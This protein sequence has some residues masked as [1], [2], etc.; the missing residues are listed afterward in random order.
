MRISVALSN[1]GGLSNTSKMPCKSYGLPAQACK[2]GAKLVKIKGSTCEGC[3]ALKGAYAWPTV[4][5]AYNR[6]IK[7]LYS[8]EWV[9]SMAVLI[10]REKN[11]VFRWHDSGDLQSLQHLQ[12]I[13]EV[14]KLTPTIRHW[15]P[16]REKAIINSHQSVY[17]DNL[18][19]RLSAAMVDGKPPTGQWLTS[20][21]HSKGADHIGYE[22]KAYE[23]DGKCNDC[24]KCW[25]N[26]VV[27][28]SYRKH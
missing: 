24:R 4:K 16:T 22:C 23:H 7:S 8:P 9:Q 13:I 12:A 10:N 25:D 2:V 1:V 21:V 5:N 27:N 26:T 20:T 17:P 14:C 18:V 11:K 6:R 3:Y 15:L 28:I 19:V